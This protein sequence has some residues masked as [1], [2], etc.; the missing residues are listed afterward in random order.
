MIKG[1]NLTGGWLSGTSP[2]DWLNLQINSVGD[3]MFF[4]L[5]LNYLRQEIYDFGL[6][7]MGNAMAW[8]GGIALT[9]MTLWILLQGYRIVSG[10]SREPM[11]A[12][13]TNALRA[14]FIVAVATSMG[15]FG[16]DLHK[17]LT[18]DVKK[19]I[20]WLVT[21]DPNST[22]ESQIDENLGWMQLAW[23]SIDAMQVVSDPEL[24]DQKKTAMWAVGFGTGGPAITAGISLLL[25]EIAMALFIGLGPIFILCLLFD[26][27]KQLFSKWL[28]YGIGTMFSMAMLSAMVAIAMKMVAKV[29]FV[30]WGT[31]IAGAILGQNFTQGMSSQALQQGGLGLILTVLIVSAPPMAAMFFQGVLGQFSSYNVFDKSGS[32]GASPGPGIP[33]QGGAQPQRA[34]ESQ[35]SQ[36]HAQ[37]QS[38]AAAPRFTGQ[39]ANAEPSPGQRGLAGNRE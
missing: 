20:N 11:M 26:Q 23:S 17:F 4:R 3:F 2:M 16:T 14:T 30:F 34:A 36:Y 38:Q 1:L 6:V 39:Q 12:L 35:G 32:Q 27:T 22:P 21:D 19:E 24:S 13:V 37:M 18:V 15:A 5:I 8:V 9:L 25:Y 10:M 7:M 28:Y 29:A 33:P 31:A